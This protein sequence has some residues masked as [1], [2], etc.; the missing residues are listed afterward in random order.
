MV[1]SSTTATR[2]TNDVTDLTRLVGQHAE[3]TVVAVTQGLHRAVA[4]RAFRW[5]P[6]SGVVRATHDAI[7]GMVYGSVRLG[8]RAGTSVA[9]LVAGAVAGGREVRWLESSPSHRRAASVLHGIVGDGFA[10]GQPALDLP[11]TVRVDGHEVP[12][13]AG[14]IASAHPDA[15]PRVAVF[16]HGLTEGDG[17]WDRDPGLVL[18]DVIAELGWTPVRLRYGTGRSIAVN[19]AD[20]DVVLERLL[21]IWPVP[22]EDL[23]L[24]GHSMGGLVI[25]AAGA[26]AT[27]AHHRWPDRVRHTVSLGTPH[28]GSWLERAANR[29]TR[30]L[31]RLP[32]GE[33]VAQVI[34]RRARGIKDLRHGALSDDCW[35]EGIV[36]DDGLDGHVP[37][38]TIV[39]PL[40]DD[41]VHHLVAGRLTHSS[42]HPVSRL[43]GDSLVLTGSA[44]GDDGRRRLTGGR[45][46]T[47]EV[48]VGHFRLLSDPAV[49]EHLRRWMA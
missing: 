10:A 13:T 26:A 34:D 17:C 35:G 46:E 25:R 27:A 18:P 8:L 14:A 19:G 47:L 37:A 4:S 40:L 38:P 7:S 23:T 39:A 42:R 30:L 3:D 15:R 33:V 6:A 49:A 45:I 11:V 22:V 16:V 1:D 12:L 41:A 24:I 20:L 28:L 48:P 21:D 36:A 5:T 32:E 44:L 2:A 43:F 31:R 9:A 29:G